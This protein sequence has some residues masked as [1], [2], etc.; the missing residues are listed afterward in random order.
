VWSQRCSFH[1]GVM[2]ATISSP[3]RIMFPNGGPNFRRKHSPFSQRFR[4]LFFFLIQRFIANPKSTTFIRK[5]V[6]IC[7]CV[8]RCLFEV[9]AP[10]TQQ[11][12]RYSYT[13]E[14]DRVL[15]AKAE[16]YQCVAGVMW[17][18]AG[19]PWDSP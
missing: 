10:G 15:R 19:N 18:T 12:V 13:P 14:G 1:S 7:T 16:R 2:I 3:E 4:E 17:S 5:L 9:T 8:L 11:S 6:C